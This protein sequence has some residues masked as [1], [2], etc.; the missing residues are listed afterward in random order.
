MFH[1]ADLLRVYIYR[2]LPVFLYLLLSWFNVSNRYSKMLHD[3]FFR[4]WRIQGGQIRP[5]L[6]PSK[7]AMEF[8][9]LGGRKSNDSIVNLPTSNDFA[10]PPYRRRLRIWPPSER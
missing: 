2:R 9:P 3:S 6:P 4:Q 1:P 8:G 5:W 10:P 7:L